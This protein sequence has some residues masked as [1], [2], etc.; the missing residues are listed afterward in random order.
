MRRGLETARIAG[1]LSGR[2]SFPCRTGLT[3]LCFARAA[4]QAEEP[5]LRNVRR[6]PEHTQPSILGAI[7]N[8]TLASFVAEISLAPST[9]RVY[10]TRALLL[11]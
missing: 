2:G 10:M 11:V 8:H 1:D 6:V 9:P 4:F 5:L 7:F 3:A